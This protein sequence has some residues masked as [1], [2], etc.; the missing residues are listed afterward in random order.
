MAII[1]KVKV[2]KG[3]VEI[4]KTAKKDGS[5]EETIIRSYE[6]PH[7]DLELAFADAVKSVYEILGMPP[8]WAIGQVK[9]TGVSYSQSEKEGGSGAVITAQA[10]VDGSDAP[11]CFNTPHLRFAP[12]NESAGGR[13]MSEKSV[14]RMTKIREEAASFLAGKHA[15]D[16]QGNLPLMEK[17]DGVP[18]AVTAAVSEPLP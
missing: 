5:D 16:P 13:F 9:V 12:P 17:I 8:G 2:N 3:V 10:L 15:P 7:P 14:E 11:F 18:G 6:K 4:H 1:T